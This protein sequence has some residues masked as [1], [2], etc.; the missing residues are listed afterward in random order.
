[1]TGQQPTGDPRRFLDGGRLRRS[2]RRWRDK[3][4]VTRYLATL[5]LPRLLEPLTERELTE[6][7]ADLADD[8]VGLRRAMVDHGLVSRTRDGAEYWRTVVTEFDAV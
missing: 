5:A 8:P 1:M 2:P 7:L 4:A 3:Q 6:R